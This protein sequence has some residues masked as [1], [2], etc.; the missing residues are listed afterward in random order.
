MPD[1][2][3]SNLQVISIRSPR[4]CTKGRDMALVNSPAKACYRWRVNACPFSRAVLL[5]TGKTPVACKNR[6]MVVGACIWKSLS[7]YFV[8]SCLLHTLGT[9]LFLLLNCVMGVFFMYL[10]VYMNS[11]ESLF[12]HFWFSI[13]QCVLSVSIAEL[14]YIAPTATSSIILWLSLFLQVRANE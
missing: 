7:L 6:P 4:N 10:S 2:P 12:R 1:V 13:H 11:L 14:T 8:P 9:P 5:G 3:L